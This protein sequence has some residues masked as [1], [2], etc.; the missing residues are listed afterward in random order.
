MSG[1]RAD[2][3]RPG[4]ILAPRR[5]PALAERPPGANDAGRSARSE[6]RRRREQDRQNIRRYLHW[7]LPLAVVGPVGVYL[8]A[9]FAVTAFNHWFEHGF[10]LRTSAATQVV[11]RAPVGG[12][13]ANV[14]ALLVACFV[15]IALA[16]AF[17][18]PREETGAWRKG[19]EG[20]E[21][22][23]RRL[24]KLEQHG[25]RVLHD[26]LVPGSQA[27][28]DH[29]VIGP[30]GVFAVD[31]KNYSGKLTLSKGTLWH[32]RHPLTKTLAVT[33]WEAER[34]SQSLSGPLVGESPDVK[35]VMCVL[36]AELPRH[37]FE[38]DGVRVISGGRR[39]VRDIENR[40]A[41]LSSEA[42]NG[43]MELAAH[44]LPPAA[45]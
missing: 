44:S 4:V 19:A 45:P 38:I 34:V 39:L 31:A 7:T 3:P 5:G 30:T 21:R 23:G 13:E 12:H 22:L 32:G 33:R 6:Y 15:A 11:S 25:F 14:L 43:L 40:R 1:P 2:D 42:V 18:G 8:A 10:G 37:R 29:L 41:V 35:P 16:R 17:W 26:R 27:N 20:E 9:R 36:G 24:Q 28:V